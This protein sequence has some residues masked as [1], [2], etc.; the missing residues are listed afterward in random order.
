VLGIIILVLL[1]Q[2]TQI[3]EIKAEK[4]RLFIRTIN[5]S[6]SL[7]WFIFWSPLGNRFNYY[8]NDC[9]MHEYGHA[10]QSQMLGPFYL[11]I[12]GIPSLL[13][14]YYSHWYLKKFGKSWNN[15][16]NSFPENWADRLGGISSK[17]KIKEL[18]EKDSSL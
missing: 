4:H 2:R 13:R 6:V 17:N 11:F 14:V 3:K 16:F 15:Y 7:G 12:I 9:R 8:E 1:K 5:T 18:P 10:R